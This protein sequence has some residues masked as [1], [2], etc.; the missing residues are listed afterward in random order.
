MLPKRSDVG[1]E[2]EHML[3]QKA[4]QVEKSQG[5]ELL[6]SLISV[7]DPALSFHEERLSEE[8]KSMAQEVVVPRE[9]EDPLT[10]RA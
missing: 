9:K 4:P 2:P 8:V 3:A 1:E 10:V 7:P 5:S 6:E